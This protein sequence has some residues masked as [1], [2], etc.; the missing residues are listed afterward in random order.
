MK[1]KVSYMNRSSKK[2]CIAKEN[3]PT[4]AIALLFCNASKGINKNYRIHCP[5]GS[6]VK[7]GNRQVYIHNAELAARPATA[8]ITEGICREYVKP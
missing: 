3:F 1:Y 4:E 5:D 7:V 2:R 8:H 6:T